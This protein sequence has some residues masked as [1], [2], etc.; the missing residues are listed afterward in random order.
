MRKKE[1]KNIRH[2]WKLGSRP[3]NFNR[4]RRNICVFKTLFCFCSLQPRKSLQRAGLLIFFYLKYTYLIVYYL[5]TVNKLEINVW[6]LEITLFYSTLNI[7]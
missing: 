3:L 6:K 5:S 4:E 1:K 7:Q 2:L